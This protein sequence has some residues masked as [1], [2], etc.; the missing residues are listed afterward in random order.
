MYEII[1]VEGGFGYKL[2]DENGNVICQ[3]PFN[4][5]KPGFVPFTEEEAHSFGS[6]A[7]KSSYNLNIDIPNDIQLNNVFNA[8]VSIKVFNCNCSERYNLEIIESPEYVC[9]C[10]SELATDWLLPVQ[11]R[12]IK[13]DNSVEKFMSNPND[14]LASFS[15]TPELVGY[16]TVEVE[17]VKPFSIASKI[18]TIQ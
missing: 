15:F 13:P 5:C 9:D 11:I 7:M 6:I 2:K 3:Q 1:E 17:T 18:F 10:E 12:I 8:T 4:P 16:Y 14:G